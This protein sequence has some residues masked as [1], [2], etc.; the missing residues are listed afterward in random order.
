MHSLSPRVTAGGLNSHPVPPDVCFAG[1]NCQR[2]N[3]K[4]PIKTISHGGKQG[5]KLLERFLASQRIISIC[6]FKID[7]WEEWL[8]Y[9]TFDSKRTSIFPQ[10]L[11][12]CAQGL[13][14]QNDHRSIDHH[15]VSIPHG[16]TPEIAR[17]PSKLS[18]SPG[19]FCANSVGFVQ[20]QKF[21]FFLSVLGS[22]R[23]KTWLVWLIETN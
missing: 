6:E 5:A 17:G 11:S 15:N 12:H 22:P 19:K 13:L 3:V 16:K 10:V 21:P 23:K 2:L 9:S 7:R 14:P 8:W 1:L 18:G 4:K 20:L